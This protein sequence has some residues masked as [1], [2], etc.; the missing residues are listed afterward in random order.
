VAV[1]LITATLV[2]EPPGVHV[3]PVAVGAT[4]VSVALTPGQVIVGVP[5][6]V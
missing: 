1:G 4:D 3:N 5:V 6:T 2:V